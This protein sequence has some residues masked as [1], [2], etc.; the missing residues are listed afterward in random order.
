M[1]DMDP[2]PPT[3]SDPAQIFTL[4]K[5]LPTDLS[6]EEIRELAATIRM[7]SF[8]SARTADEY[9]L[10]L[11]QEKI[12]GI[13]TGKLPAANA[14][15]GAGGSVSQFNAAYVRQSIKEFLAETGYEAA[16]GEE[17]TIKD[18]SSDARINLIVKTNTEL[19]QGQG[20]WIKNQEEAL[21]DEWPGQ[22]LFRAESR[23]QPRKWL[24]RWRIA[25]A[26]TGDPIGTG[27]TITPDERMI[28]LKNHAIW[29]WIGS[30][31]LFPDA[32]DVIWPPFA[33]NS[34]MW[35]RDVDRDAIEKI[36]LLAKGQPAPKPMN[37]VNAL[38]SFAQKISALSKAA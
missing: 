28:A 4:K 25:G 16:P 35:V 31:E 6:S 23:V 5:I 8:F 22:E 7:Q 33:F 19:S 15:G 26:A 21:L 18:L 1:A 10:G 11:Y 32:L 13:L 20:L 3:I 9:L 29:N 17:G 37:I 34:G 24:M 27:W 2:I 38:E 36:G 12:G 30:S 14:P